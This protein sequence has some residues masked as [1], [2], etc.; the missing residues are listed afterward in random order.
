MIL[1]GEK[2]INVI[3]FKQNQK[4]FHLFTRKFSHD[5]MVCANNEDFENTM[6][7][8]I[9]KV[10][11]FL[12][13]KGDKVIMYDDF[14]YKEMYF[15]NLNLAKTKTR[16]PIEII[17]MKASADGQYVALSIGKNLITGI[18]VIV[19]II[20]IRRNPVKNEFSIIKRIDM[21]KNYMTDVCKRI[22]FDNKNPNC[23]I[24]VDA[25]MVIRYNF[26]TGK[27]EKIFDFISDFTEQPE[28]F[29][30]NED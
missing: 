25:D 13:A 30:F 21:A 15:I 17:S 19:E 5:F 2:S 23:L 27:K 6:G 8:T 24:F 16:E 11:H 29:I 14:D 9:D 20:V 18:E 10:N 28:F 1:I 26:I 7:L 3:A 12:I 4:D 22:C